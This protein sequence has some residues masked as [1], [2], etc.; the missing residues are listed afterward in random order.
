[1]SFFC[2]Y[3]ELPEGNNLS[4]IVSLLLRKTQSIQ[5]YYQYIFWF[6]VQEI[7]S[8]GKK[9]VK[10]LGRVQLFVTLWIVAY[11]ALSVHGI[12]QARLLEWVAISFS[13]G[14]S[15]PRDWTQVSHIAG[16][17]FTLWATRE[18]FI[19]QICHTHTHT[20]VPNLKKLGERLCLFGPQWLPP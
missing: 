6:R 16:R 8:S 5:L 15:R 14:S 1:M 12:L 7:V 10:S 9:K 4:R 11:Q 19:W 18:A 17:R 13:R 3:S 2:N 20:K